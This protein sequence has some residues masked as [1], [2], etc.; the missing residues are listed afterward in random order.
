MIM[1]NFIVYLHVCNML[2]SNASSR[3]FLKN[4]DKLKKL[5]LQDWFGF[6]SSRPTLDNYSSVKYF[7]T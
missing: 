7:M 6:P 1:N 2:L 3:F 4:L 5:L